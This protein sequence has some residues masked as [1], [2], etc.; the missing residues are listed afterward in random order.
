MNDLVEVRQAL[1]RGVVRPEDWSRLVLAVERVAERL[2]RHENRLDNLSD[3]LLLV[4]ELPAN[5][6][7]GALLRLRAGTLA[8][9]AALYLGNGA[10]QPLTKLTPQTVTAASSGTQAAKPDQANR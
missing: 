10:G 2:A 3:R 5:A 9:R 4:D 1:Q 8:D 7:Y 6:P